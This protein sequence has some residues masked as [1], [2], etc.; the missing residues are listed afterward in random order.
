MAQRGL[1]SRREA[2]R[3]IEQGL[4]LVDGEPVTTLGTKVSE[5]QTITLAEAAARQQADKVTVLLNK[6]MGYVSGLPEDG[7]QS[8]VLLISRE[9][10]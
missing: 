2:D 8:A 3:F 1:C 7:H 10:P 5:S 9:E 6:P 4:V